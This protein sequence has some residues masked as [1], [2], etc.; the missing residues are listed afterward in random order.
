MKN[1]NLKWLDFFLHLRISSTVLEECLLLHGNIWIEYELSKM[2]N[3]QT[4]LPSEVNVV[5]LLGDQLEAFSLQLKVL[6]APV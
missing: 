4:M 2:I 5:E 6:P 1:Y 3:F